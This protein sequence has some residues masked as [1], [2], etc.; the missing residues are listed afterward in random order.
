MATLGKI[1]RMYFRDGLSLS[2]ISRGTSLSRNTIR[3]WLKKPQGSE[4]RYRRACRPGKLTA[5]EAILIGG[6]EADARRPKRDRRSALALF[7][8][9]KRQGYV[10]GY[11]LVTDFVR[12]WRGRDG[13]ALARAFVPLKF[14]LRETFQFDWSEEGLVI[15]GVWR[16]LLVTHMKLCASRA[17]VLVAYPS[18]GHSMP[19]CSS[20]AARC[21]RRCATP[22]IAS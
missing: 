1:R 20:A 16:H 11:T 12:H 8:E 6:L 9:L 15:A 21:G 14:E 2:E 10:G 7:A 3:A 22:S 5:F 19:G 17:F 4:P 18:Q 13:K